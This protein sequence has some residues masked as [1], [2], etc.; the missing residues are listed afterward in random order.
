VTLAER[1]AAYPPPHSIPG[2]RRALREALVRGRSKI[3]VMDDDP[4]G[5][6]TVHGVRVLMSWSVPSLLS[7]L[8]EDEPLFFIST[9]SRS[10]PSEEASALA[11]QVGRNLRAAGERSGTRIV[12]ASRSDST[13]R[14][15]FPAEVDALA[16][17]M[18]GPVDA[19]LLVPAFFDAGRY[20]IDNV[21]W[22]DTGG[23]LVPAHQTEFAR[24]PDFG[25]AHGNLPEWVEE[26]T[27]GRRKAADVACISLDDVRRGG[28]ERV[29]RILAA[30]HGGAPVV[31]N[32]ACDE[33]LEVVALGAS[34]AEDAGKSLLYRT[35][36]SFVKVRAGIEDR[37]LLTRE[38]MGPGSAAGI[39]VVGSY[40]AR[41]TA[42]V[43]RLVES[44]RAQPIEI[45]VD[46]LLGG[47]TRAEEIGRA[48]AAASRAIEKGR[49]ALLYTSRT[50]LDSADFLSA[51]RRIMEALCAIVG[52]IG[53]RPGFVIAKGGITSV[54]IARDALACAEALV[55]GQVL[56]GVPVWRLGAG[57]KWSAVPYVVFPGN[58]GD[59]SSL[60]ATVE[61][62]QGS[63][64]PENGKERS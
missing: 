53:P 25:Y 32:A 55:L 56:R 15:H 19:V 42:Q 18:G 63:D 47:G 16:G 37:R 34:A 35:S 41:T 40:V 20:T 30:A 49:T 54:A 8:G 2:A 10:L 43:D 31:V 33:D 44:G 21:H 39:V 12:P 45:L 29:S 59:A 4:T 24:D 46:R 1:L 5:T 17:E 50:R 27:G 23:T 62:L 6:Q 14:G 3:A 36:A 22:V 38:E 13:L 60:L 9:N 61:I 52:G 51:G 28:P 58:V 7:A 48:T 11:A 26:K 64:S 57:S